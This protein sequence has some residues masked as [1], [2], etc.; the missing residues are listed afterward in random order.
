MTLRRQ[1][2]RYLLQLVAHRKRCEMNLGF[3]TMLDIGSQR[4]RSSGID[5]IRGGIETTPDRAVHPFGIMATRGKKIDQQNMNP[6]SRLKTTLVA[7]S[8]TLARR[9]LF[10][11]DTISIKAMT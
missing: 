8:R 5:L 3:I 10:P 4:H 11:G 9:S 7:S 1:K 6:A 2:Q